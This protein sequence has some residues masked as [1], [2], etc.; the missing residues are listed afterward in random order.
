MVQ[1]HYFLHFEEYQKV[2]NITQ[3]KH[4]DTQGS[5]GMQIH[6]K[7]LIHMHNREGPLKC[8]PLIYIAQV[9]D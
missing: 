1:L 5:L 8:L 7:P 9:L 6:M 3:K 4:L 2:Q